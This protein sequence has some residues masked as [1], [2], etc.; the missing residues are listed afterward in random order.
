MR[1][2]SQRPVYRSGSWKIDLAKREQY[3]PDY[4]AI[5]PKSKVPV[6]QRDDGTLLTELPASA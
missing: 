1:N 4:T 6:L 5:N 3:G 2:S